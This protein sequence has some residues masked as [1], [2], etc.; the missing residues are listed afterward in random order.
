MKEGSILQEYQVRTLPTLPSLNLQAIFTV[1]FLNLQLSVPIEWTGFHNHHLSPS[2]LLIVSLIQ[3]IHKSNWSNHI[4]KTIPKPVPCP[5]QFWKLWHEIQRYL[6]GR[7]A[8]LDLIYRL[9]PSRLLLGC[10]F[11]IKTFYWMPIY[12]SFQI[13]PLLAL[14]LSLLLISL[15]LIIQLK[16]SLPVSGFRQNLILFDM[17]VLHKPTYKIDINTIL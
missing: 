13:L 15:Q 4:L 6:K 3:L 1:I 12:F 14:G 11:V 7:L 5:A 10:F 2:V 9:N 16:N 8:T 17:T